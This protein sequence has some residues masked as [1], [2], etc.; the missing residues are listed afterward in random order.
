MK[1]YELKLR[2]AEVVKMKSEKKERV[3]KAA[4]EE[5]GLKIMATA[6]DVEKLNKTELETLLQWHGIAK[7][8]QPQKN[9]ERRAMWKK[10]KD[11]GKPPPLLLKWSDSEEQKLIDLQKTEIYISETAIGRARVTYK[12]QAESFISNLEKDERAEFIQEL[13]VKIEKKEKPEKNVEKD[14]NGN[15]FASI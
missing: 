9:P 4:I 6:T 11:E 1:A 3:A 5:E 2:D 13:Q 10:L 14:E 12:K 8:D 7:K 15:E